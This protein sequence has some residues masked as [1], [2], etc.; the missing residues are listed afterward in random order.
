MSVSGILDRGGR[1]PKNDR[2]DNGK[3]KDGEIGGIRLLFITLRLLLIRT[4]EKIRGRGVVASGRLYG[5]PDAQGP[6]KFV[7]L[8]QT[9]IGGK[10][11]ETKSAL[12][13]SAK[14]LGPSPT[15]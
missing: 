5:C 10:Q 6:E 13:A 2:G 1:G 14:E 15:N 7:C 3:K 8:R 12:R 4:C 11:T 9:K